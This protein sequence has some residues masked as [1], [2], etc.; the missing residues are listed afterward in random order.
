MVVL[1]CNNT[2]LS[3][4]KF[5]LGQLSGQRFIGYRICNF[6]PILSFILETICR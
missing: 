4:S 5:Q 6:L 3:C 2:V 1:W